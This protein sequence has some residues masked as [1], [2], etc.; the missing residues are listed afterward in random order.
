M[1]FIAD[2]INY[3]GVYQAEEHHE[4]YSCP[5]TGAH[6]QFKDLCLRLTKIELWRKAY[7]QA[8]R[9]D[10]TESEITQILL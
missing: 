10:L 4:K 1:I 3:K 9:S 2:I 5:L 6:F 7:L 8:I